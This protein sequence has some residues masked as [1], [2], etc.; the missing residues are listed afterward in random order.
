MKKNN[1]SNKKNRFNS[2]KYNNK[3]MKNKN[4]NNICNN[5]CLQCNNMEY[6]MQCIYLMKIECYNKNYLTWKLIIKI[7]NVNMNNYMM[8]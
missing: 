7:Y 1:N 3:V 4:H 6:Q 2:N 5:K 8:I